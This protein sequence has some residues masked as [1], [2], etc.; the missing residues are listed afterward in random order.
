[1]ETKIL[2]KIGGR[3]AQLPNRRKVEVILFDDVRSLCECIE[4]DDLILWSFIE[5]LDF[6]SIVIW[7]GIDSEMLLYKI[8]DRVPGSAWVKSAHLVANRCMEEI[9]RRYLE[10]QATS[11]TDRFKDLPDRN[12][13][14]M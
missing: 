2:L 7:Y 14:G 6:E 13:G 12:R 11:L 4:K 1:M 8:V 9:H 10:C 3:L 5:S